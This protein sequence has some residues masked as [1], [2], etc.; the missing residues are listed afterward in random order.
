MVRHLAIEAEPTEPAVSAPG[1]GTICFSRLGQVSFVSWIQRMTDNLFIASDPKRV[2][3]KT[4]SK[5]TMS[6]AAASDSP[7]KTSDFA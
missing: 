5:K 4:S 1:P 6:G 3:R 7:E 2:H